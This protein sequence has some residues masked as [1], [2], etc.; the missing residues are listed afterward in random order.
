MAV[1]LP[2]YVIEQ[3][4]TATVHSSSAHNSPH[5][6][7]LANDLQLKSAHDSLESTVSSLQSSVASINALKEYASAYYSPSGAY[8]TSKPTISNILVPASTFSSFYYVE[9][10]VGLWT[11]DGT[12]APG[13]YVY[14]VHTVQKGAWTPS[15]TPVPVSSPWG[16]VGIYT[17]KAGSTGHYWGRETT[18]IRQFKHT[19]VTTSHS[20]QFSAGRAAY[21]DYSSMWEI[22][23][24]IYGR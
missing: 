7:L 6:K 21:P 20:F 23:I 12:S 3:F 11:P 5:N 24:R 8:W 22:L 14:P 16:F 13:V 19:D 9:I 17:A 2:Y 10:Q 1:T 4:D 18:I 15:L